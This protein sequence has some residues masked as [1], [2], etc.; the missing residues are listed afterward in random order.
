M[1]KNSCWF[2]AAIDRYSHTYQRT[3]HVPCQMITFHSFLKSENLKC[4]LLLG[5]TIATS[6]I[7]NSIEETECLCVHYSQAHYFIQWWSLL[8]LLVRN[9]Q[10]NLRLDQFH[11]HA[12]PT[13]IEKPDETK[14]EVEEDRKHT[15]QKPNRSMIFHAGARA[16]RNTTPYFTHNLYILNV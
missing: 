4:H 8:R 11:R 15:T 5:H 14:V 6:P 7:A 2:V 1:D 10:S 3:T 9:P 13:K 16:R 12:K